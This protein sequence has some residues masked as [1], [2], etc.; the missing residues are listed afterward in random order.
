MLKI[1]ILRGRPWCNSRGI[2]RNS[3]FERPLGARGSLVPGGKVCLGHHHIRRTKLLESIQRR[4]LKLVK[5]LEGKTYE[6]QLKSL[7]LFSPEQSSLRGGL[8]AAC[9][10]FTRGAE[11]QVLSSALWEQRQDPREQHGAGTG[12]CQAGC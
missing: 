12:E 6:E 4:A 10:F 8:M 7:G 11:G 2:F 5:D 3:V 9:N 1:V